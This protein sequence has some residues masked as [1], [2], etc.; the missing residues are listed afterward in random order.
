MVAGVARRFEINSNPL[1]EWLRQARKGRLVLPALHGEVDFAPVV[2]RQEER[3]APASG[4]D[5]LEVIRERVT[6]RLNADTLP[7]R[8]AEIVFALNASA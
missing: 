4:G 6:I 2:L 1:S 3:R 7:G 5:R 8:I